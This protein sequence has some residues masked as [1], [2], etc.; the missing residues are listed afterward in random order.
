[1]SAAS[2]ATGFIC[3]ER[4]F[5]HDTGNGALDIPTGGAVEP[6]VLG[7]NPAT[8]RRARNLV[9]VSGLLGQLTQISPRQATVAELQSFHTPKYVQRIRR[10]SRLGAGDAGDGN[11]PFRA[12]SFEI[13]SLAVGACMT[14]VDAILDG[15]V[16]HVYVLNRPPGH[17]AQPDSGAGFC[18]FNNA[19][20]ATLHAR[21]RGVGRVA[22]LD[23]DAHHG[24]GTQAAFWSSREVLFASMHQ[25]RY[26]PLD[27]GLAEE[28][29]SQDAGGFTVN[30]PM[31]AGSGDGAYLHAFQEVLLPIL[32]KFAPELIVVSSGLDPN[33]FDPFSQL[34][35]TSEGFRAMTANLCATALRLGCGIVCC[36]EGGYSEG[37]VPFCLLAVLEALSGVK[38]WVA[39]PFLPAVSANPAGCLQP[40][41]A[42]SVARVRA[43]QRPFWGTLTPRAD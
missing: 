28:V 24:N 19:V 32:E 23:W 15:K 21:K 30:V 35:V 1:M 8:K 40:H 43:V 6:G 39:D 10:L 20:L 29:G 9:E 38:T 36:H 25:D 5:W 7:E 33:F 18:I 27:S 16:R 34:A 4:F 14:G 26:Y 31:P 42:A 22:V 13:A 3:D 41:E 11:T 2:H 17:H 12:G 37:Y